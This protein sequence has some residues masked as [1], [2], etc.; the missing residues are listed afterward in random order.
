MV[1]GPDDSPAAGVL[2]GVLTGAEPVALLP[3]GAH[4]VDSAA[5]ISAACR[6]RDARRRAAPLRDVPDDLLAAVGSPALSLITGLI[7]RAAARRTPMVLDG[8]A[9]VAAAL[10]CREFQARATRWCRL[11]D[12]SPDPV[13]TRASGE[14]GQRPLLDLG[15]TSS[16]GVAGLLCLPL[17]RAAAALAAGHTPAPPQVQP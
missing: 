9:A 11:A 5:W 13:H 15:S 7:L 2:V 10:L 4:A 17:L 8:T 12:S 1:A 6:S 3:R 16:G 14:L